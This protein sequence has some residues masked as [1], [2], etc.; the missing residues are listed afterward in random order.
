MTD[1]RAP[2]D[3]FRKRDGT[4]V[5]FEPAKIE[6]A[7]RRA[8]EAVTS[9]TGEPVS[10]ALPATITASVIAQLNDPASDYH[11]Y[12][13]DDGRRVPLIE[14]V[15][16]LV[17]IVLAEE[18]YAA[19]VTAYK[20]YRKQ[21]DVARRRIRVRPDEDAAPADVTDASLL[22]VESVTGDCTLPWD[23]TRIVRHLVEKAGLSVDIAS[24]IAK[25]VENHVIEGGLRTVNS[26]LI[27]ELVNNELRDRGCRNQLRD[28]SIYGIPREYVERLMF[29]KSAENSNIVNNITRISK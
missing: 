18:G 3:G 28:L 16:D 20:R 26:A 24:G 12:P 1:A 22:L 14:D 8:A 21:R 6:N 2:F 4:E 27:R 10:T 17:E 29:T 25:A 15:Q 7:V 19:V 11:V 23:R 13:D 9:R 5:L